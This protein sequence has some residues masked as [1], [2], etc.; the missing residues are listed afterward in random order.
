M[1]K[2]RKRINFSLEPISAMNEKQKKV[3]S[4]RENQVLIGS[5][6]TGKTFLA[7]YLGL[8]EVLDERSDITKLVFF[9]SAV[10]TRD[11]GFLPGNEKEKMEVYTSPYKGICSEL[12]KNGT[13]FEEL[14]FKGNIGFQPTSFVRG[15]TLKNTFVIVDECQN[16]TFHELDSLITRLGED[17]KI[18]F[19]GDTEQADLKN[20]GFGRFHGILR[21]MEEFSTT[22]FEIE[23]IVRS[24][25]VKSY[26]RNKSRYSKG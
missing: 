20:N 18:I 3:L 26:L 19:C 11:I 6:G 24:D 10:P 1:S 25:L 15:T 14:E 9:R 17:C 13:A 23:D 7:T 2:K 8:K 4:C 16:M 5:A 12:L 21:T 22:S